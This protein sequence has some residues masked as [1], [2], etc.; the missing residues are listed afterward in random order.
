MGRRRISPSVGNQYLKQAYFKDTT[1]GKSFNGFAFAN[2][3]EG[4]EISVPNPTKGISFKTVIGPKGPTT[5]RNQTSDTALIFEGF[6]D[7][8]SFLEMNKK[9]K[10]DQ[11]A[12]ILNSLSF[13][14]EAAEGLI[15]QKDTIKKV[16][17]FQDNDDAGDKALLLMADLLHSEDFII[18]TMNHLYTGKKDLN[19]FWREAQGQIINQVSEP[20]IYAAGVWAEQE[21][22]KILNSKQPN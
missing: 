14:K 5:I 1:T 3:R 13:I 17:L 12:I 11:Q 15:K 18:G 20:K 6:W 7:Y 16:F 9:T 2:D 4:Y 21:R 19:D 22:T 8:L 10:L